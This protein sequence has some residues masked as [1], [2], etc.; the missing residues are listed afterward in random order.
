[1]LHFLFFPCQ[2]VTYLLT[3][4]NYFHC[5]TVMLLLGGRVKRENAKTDP[6]L[7]TETFFFV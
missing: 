3:M 2:P 6:Q 1:M 5:V 7:F 4:A